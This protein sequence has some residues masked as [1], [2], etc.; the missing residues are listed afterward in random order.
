MSR[1]AADFRFPN[2]SVEQYDAII[3]DF[4]AAVE[5]DPSLVEGRV[6]H[7]AIPEGDGMCIFDVWESGEALQRIG[8]VLAPLLDKH[9][10]AMVAPIVAPVHAT[11]S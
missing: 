2:M 8:E 11:M 9:G 10:V 5:A 1:I 6:I 3:V 4:N 7:V